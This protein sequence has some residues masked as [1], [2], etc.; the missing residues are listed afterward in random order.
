[1]RTTVYWFLVAS[2]W[3]AVVYAAY[4]WNGRNAV[5][6]G[7]EMATMRG[8]LVFELIQ[9]TRQW[10]ARHG[11]VYVP[12]TEETPDN[13]YLIT[14]EKNIQTPSGIRL[15]KVNPAYMTRQLGELLSTSQVNIH[16]TSLNPLNPGN[17]ADAWETESLRAFETGARERITIENVGTDG[18]FR[19]MAPLKVEKPCLACHEAQG[20]RVGDVRGGLSVSFSA[21]FITDYVENRRQAAIAPHLIAFLALTG[22]SWLS[23]AIFRTRVVAL[24]K[25][26]QAR[27]RIIEQRTRDL[28]NE[29][30]ARRHSEHVLAEREEMIRSILETAGE[31]IYEIDPDGICLMANPAAVRMLGYDS[32]DD[33]VGHP[34]HDMIHYKNGDGAPLPLHQCALHEVAR[35]GKAVTLVDEQLVR[36]DGTT[37]PV[38]CYSYPVMQGG[39]VAAA[40]VSFFDVT[41]QK[42]LEAELRALAI[43]DYQTQIFNRRYFMERVTDEIERTH[44]YDVSLSLLL[45][46]LDHFK[47]V[48]D[49]YGHAAGDAALVTFVDAVRPQL[50]TSDTFG[51][52]GGEEFALLLPNTSL[53]QAMVLAERLRDLISMV[54]VTAG[55]DSFGFTVSVG[56]TSVAGRKGLSVHDL[57]NEADEALYQAK[58]R[59]RDRVEIYDGTSTESREKSVSRPA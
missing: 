8:R 22:L 46:D 20:Y 18:V 16:L 32:V 59:G 37:L 36:R 13:P 2:F 30:S 42:H 38:E 47:N 26:K 11:G 49:T 24:E 6:H 28:E 21:G 12:L 39:K 25:E 53:A 23:L 7:R 9:T 52:L 56:V 10:N 48:N 45:F 55:G 57:V 54:V 33:L 58:R 19:F 27:E 40:V 44:R 3:G 1:M 15:T 35:T 31:G 41:R 5:E 50:R 17:R 43:H 29:I 4:L 51:R 34:I 14:F